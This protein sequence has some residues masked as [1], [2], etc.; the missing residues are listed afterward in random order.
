MRIL[1][2]LI[3]SYCRGQTNAGATAKRAADGRIQIH[4]I[5]GASGGGIAS[6]DSCFQL[7][8]TQKTLQISAGILS[9]GLAEVI[10]GQEAAETVQLS[11]NA[12]T[13]HLHGELRR[14]R[15]DGHLVK[16]RKFRQLRL[17]KVH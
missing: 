5:S 13:K 9:S 17:S 15:I 1:K 16:T 4:P 14:Q 6:P 2:L 3:A 11:K 12:S 8:Y 10:R 7:F